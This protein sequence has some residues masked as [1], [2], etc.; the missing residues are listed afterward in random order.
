MVV[1]G[2]ERFLRNV[3]I[4]TSIEGDLEST[5]RAFGL[6]FFKL[7]TDPNGVRLMRAIIAEATRFPAL[8][9]QFYDNGPKR[10]RQQLAAFFAHCHAGGHMHAP[11]PDFAAIQFITLMKGHCQFRSLF[12]LSP[13]A[14][15]ITPHA[16][17]EQ[18]VRLFLYGCQ[19]PATPNKKPARSRS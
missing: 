3:A 16:F 2:C 15:T 4:P 13:L 1:N 8:A 10:A 19:P 7:F 5:L 12:G 17:V 18:A 14:L 9:Q 11:D 6:R